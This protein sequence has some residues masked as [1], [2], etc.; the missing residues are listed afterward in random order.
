M[1][2]AEGNFSFAGFITKLSQPRHD[3]DITASIQ[4]ADVSSFMK[5]FDNFGQNSVTYHDVDGKIHADISFHTQLGHGFKVIPSSMRG[6]M[7]VSIKDGELKN[8]ESLEQIS[9]YA[10]KD[11][12][13]SDITFSGV[14]NEYELSGSEITFSHLDV[15]SSVLTFFAEGKYDFNKTNTLMLI[16]VP[17]GNIKKAKTEELAEHP[18]SNRKSGIGLTLKAE[19]GDDN[20]M[21]ITPVVFGKKK[22][23]ED[24][25]S[26]E[27]M[28]DEEAAD[29]AKQKKS[30]EK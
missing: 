9:K 13:F 17:L 14:E 12:D 19:Y 26:K 21:H 10:F 30:N 6:K 24:I 15:Y 4:N 16:Y 2:A 22:I 29:I 28:K 25:K 11:R 7:K 5:G 20:K 1:K 27:T 8:F 23:K 18:D 3:V